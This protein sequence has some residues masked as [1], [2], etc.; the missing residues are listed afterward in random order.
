MNNSVLERSTEQAFGF[1]MQTLLR[2]KFEQ[3]IEFLIRIRGFGELQDWEDVK[4]FI[5]L[6]L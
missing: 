4:V 3:R 1:L 6:S 2:A 5:H